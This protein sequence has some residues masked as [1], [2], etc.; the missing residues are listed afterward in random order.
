[1]GGKE[2]GA[3]GRCGLG[4]R[5]KDGKR[6]RG[7]FREVASLI[8]LICCGAGLHAVHASYGYCTEERLMIYVHMYKCT[9]CASETGR[10]ST[11]LVQE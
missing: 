5:G 3:G 1:M 8:T 9:Q 6:E 2:G 10:L 4:R 7:S 11:D